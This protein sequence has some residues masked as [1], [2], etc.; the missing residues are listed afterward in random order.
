MNKELWNSLWNVVYWPVHEGSREFVD[1]GLVSKTEFPA[2]AVLET[3]WELEVLII[4]WLIIQSTNEDETDKV[5]S[6]SFLEDACRCL[7]ISPEEL[8][9]AIWKLAAKGYGNIC[10]TNADGKVALR[11]DIAGLRKAGLLTD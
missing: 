6:F 2:L 5:V 10:A 7:P 4:A 11:A 8:E 9:N 1:L 3:S